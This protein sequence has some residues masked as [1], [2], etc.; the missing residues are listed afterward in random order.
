MTTIFDLL[1]L[2]A[3][4]APALIAVALVVGIVAGETKE[5]R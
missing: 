2:L 1:H 4:A 5:A 3:V